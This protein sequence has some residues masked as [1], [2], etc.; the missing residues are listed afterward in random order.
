MNWDTIS[1][2]WNQV[3]AFLATAEEGS[4][5]AAARALKQTQ[6]TLSRQV[7][8][9]EDR[10]GVV[11]FE[12]NRRATELTEA[13][14]ELLEHVRV[15]ADAATR[16]S[17]SATGRSQAIDG[18]VSITAT[19]MTA[20][21]ILPDILVGLREVAPNISA[22]ILPSNNVQDLLRRDADIAI[23]HAR[24]EQEDLIARKVGESA[25]HLYASEAY[26][27][28]RGMPG[29]VGAL[30]SHDFLGLA[31]IER[32][33]PNIRAGGLALEVAQFPYTTS[34]GV[35]LI[36]LVRKGLGIGILPD[37]IACR[38]PGLKPVLTNAFS[39]P[40]PIWLVTHR[41]LHTSRRIRL[42][43]DLLADRL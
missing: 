13:G 26:L 7:S 33:L 35:T 39:V 28:A 29:D 3:R 4:L 9:L 23:R 41:E 1:F 34:N 43:F 8:A 10:L 18:H 15:M 21:Y 2:D 17:L 20:A 30:A 42:V 19:D 38:F 11:L 27:E 37:N 25:A 16:V 22:E 24:P 14:L 32:H 40:I 12:R 36:E 5:S 6:P 31:P